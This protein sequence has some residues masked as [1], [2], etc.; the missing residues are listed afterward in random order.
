MAR[1]RAPNIMQKDERELDIHCS[2]DLEWCSSDNAGSIVMPAGNVPYSALGWTQ[3]GI[4]GPNPEVLLIAAI[5]SCYS[6]TLA[7]LLQAAAL[8]QKHISVHAEGVIVCDLGRAQFTRV[9]VNP[10]IRGADALRRDAYQK[11]A[12]AA[13]DDCLVG[14]SIRG[15]VA[16]VV[17]DVALRQSTD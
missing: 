17:G 10:T 16:Y 1:P 4:A 14:R 2:V 6:I 3:D 8:P 5:S 7:N 13:R 11:A 15:N 9:T 12:I